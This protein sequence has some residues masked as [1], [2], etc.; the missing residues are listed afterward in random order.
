MTNDDSSKQ[1]T[2]WLVV[3]QVDIQASVIDWIDGRSEQA[4][5]IVD[6]HW[7]IDVHWMTEIVKAYGPCCYHVDQV[8]E[9]HGS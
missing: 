6:V 2:G 4:T 1:A 5:A 3:S 9:S 7:M 8:N